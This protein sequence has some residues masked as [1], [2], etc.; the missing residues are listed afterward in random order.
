ML[1][2]AAY[3]NADTHLNRPPPMR[4]SDEALSPHLTLPHAPLL[5]FGI[6]ATHGDTEAMTR[7]ANIL[8]S[9]DC[10]LRKKRGRIVGPANGVKEK[11]SVLRRR[12]MAMYEQPQPHTSTPLP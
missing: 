9:E 8:M 11:A 6:A 4:C 2:R 7:L 10:E 12:A 3:L 1:G 5:R